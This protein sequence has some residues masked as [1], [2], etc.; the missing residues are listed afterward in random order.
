[1]S[2]P[3][4]TPV[5][6][7]LLWRLR[8]RRFRRRPSGPAILLYHSISDRPRDPLGLATP[9]GRFSRHLAWLAARRTVLP[10]GDFVSLHRSGGLPSQAV[11]ITFDDG[12][13]DNALVAEPLL[14]QHSLHGT[15]FVAAAG[16]GSGREPW[17]EELDALVLADDALRGRHRIGDLELDF[18]QGNE[19]ASACQWTVRQ[20]ALLARQQGFLRLSA[21]AAGL[22]PRKR[23]CLLDD[24]AKARG[25]RPPPREY[26]RFAEWGE[27]QKAASGGCL[28]LGAHTLHHSRLSALDDDEALQELDHGLLA[29]AGGCG[30][31]PVGFAYPFGTAADFGPREQAM[32]RRAGLHWACANQPA[33]LSRLAGLFGL[34]RLLVTTQSTDELARLLGDQP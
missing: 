15:V 16:P 9:V 23:Q 19:P 11:A 18:G 8:S 29:H 22:P 31:S 27:L 2:R 34:P 21:H 20:P 4:H 12:Y 7:R 17:W 28:A 10:L 33:H 14:R 32:V 13:A 6:W 26:A 25:G 24:L 5:W 3:M 30:I 1:M